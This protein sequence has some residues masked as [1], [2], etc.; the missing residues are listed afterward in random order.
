MSFYVSPLS[1]RYSAA[2]PKQTHIFLS[3]HI[4]VVPLRRRYSF[5]IINLT[6]YTYLIRDGIKPFTTITIKL[7]Y[8][9]HIKTGMSLSNKNC[10]YAN[11]L[12]RIRNQVNSIVIVIN[13]GKYKTTPNYYYYYN[14]KTLFIIICFYIFINFMESIHLLDRQHNL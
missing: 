11:M 2:G 12:W 13:Q 7:I 1:L 8:N 3:K 14:I 10:I 5:W 6:Q 9:N 4:Y